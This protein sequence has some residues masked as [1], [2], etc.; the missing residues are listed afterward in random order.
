MRIALGDMWPTIQ[1]YS[2]STTETLVQNHSYWVFEALDDARVLKPEVVAPL[3]MSM[4]VDEELNQFIAL[5]YAK[6]CIGMICSPLMDYLK[7]GGNYG[8]LDRLAL[9]QTARPLIEIYARSDEGYGPFLNEPGRDLLAFLSR[10]GKDKGPFGAATTATRDTGVYLCCHAATLRDDCNFFRQFVDLVLLRLFDCTARIVGTHE[11][12]RVIAMRD[13]L[14]SGIN[15]CAT[16]FN[17][18]ARRRDRPA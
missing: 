5:A 2:Q 16:R 10:F 18:H 1:G 4:P 15:D 14:A 6:L 13:R 12:P 11:E 8:D 3:L 9:A 17:R 7:R